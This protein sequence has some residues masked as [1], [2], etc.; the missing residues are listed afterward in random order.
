VQNLPN[1]NIINIS[2]GEI[3][4]ENKSDCMKG[5]TMFKMWAV[6]I[7][8]GI[9]IIV[10]SVAFVDSF[11]IEPLSG[12]IGT[13][14]VFNSDKLSVL[15]ELK[16]KFTEEKSGIIS[17]ISPSLIADMDISSLM[18]SL[19]NAPIEWDSDFMYHVQRSEQYIP[20]CRML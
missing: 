18:S 4:G 6:L 9:L 1:P 5:K 10:P 13:T 20:S 12:Q 11:L 3:L 14:D 15:S 8:V 2:L 19:K 17:E 7:L 16:S